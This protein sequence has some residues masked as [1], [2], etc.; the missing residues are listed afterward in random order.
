MLVIVGLIVA[1]YAICRLVQ[2]VFEMTPE[3]DD[4]WKGIS[5]PVRFIII[6]VVSALGILLLL[7]LSSCLM[8]GFGGHG[9][10]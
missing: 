8:F 5:Y 10:I 7:A 3:A 4:G 1:V 6:A 2:V 9:G